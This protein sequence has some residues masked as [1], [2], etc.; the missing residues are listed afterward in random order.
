[1]PTSAAPP[2]PVEEVVRAP[3]RSAKI[4]RTFTGHHLLH[5]DAYSQT[6]EELPTGKYLYIEC[7]SGVGGSSWRIHY[8]P[9]GYDDYCDDC[10]SVFV[11]IDRSAAGIEP[12]R[13]LARFSLLDQAGKPVQSH[14][15]TATRIHDFIGDSC[16]AYSRYI[17]KRWL[18]KSEHLKDDRFT[19][20][21]DVIVTM[22]LPAVETTDASPPPVKVPPSDLHRHLGN[23]LES[24]EG[25]DVTFQVAGKTFKAHR[26]ILGFRSDVFRAELLGPMKEGTNRESIIHVDDMEAEVFRALLVFVY[27]DRLPDDLGC[28]E[29]EEEL[30]MAQHL[31]VAADRYNL[32]RLRLMCEDKLC[33]LNVINTGSVATILV[34]ADQHNCPRLKEACFQFLRVPLNLLD[35]V[36]TEDFDRL[37]QSYYPNVWEEILGNTGDRLSVENDEGVQEKSR[38]Y[39]G[40]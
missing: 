31:L 29:E 11:G 27:T 2:A 4:R 21:C 28:M 34:L 3:S 6:K 22:N 5:I 17:E 25:A 26:Y 7:L 8:Y 40:N 33:E 16:V 1:M 30:A 13:A 20:R 39:P 12:C 35:V 14:V 38:D 18:E 24:A 36:A 32:E 15:R 9:N 23:L 10:I 37:T 19:I